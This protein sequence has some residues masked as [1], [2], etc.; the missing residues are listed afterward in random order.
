MELQPH[1]DNIIALS[2]LFLREGSYLDFLGTVL[3]VF[4]LV[5]LKL[6]IKVTPPTIKITCTTKFFGKTFIL[7][8]ISSFKVIWQCYIQRENDSAE[9]QWAPRKI[10]S[11]SNR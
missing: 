10:S 1:K 6:S 8:S 3:R 9:T 11:N 5:L 7:Q 4:F 2:S